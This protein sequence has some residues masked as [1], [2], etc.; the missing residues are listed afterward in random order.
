MS[1]ASS[2][3]DPDAAEARYLTEGGWFR[4]G[5]DPH[6]DFLPTFARSSRPALIN[7]GRRDYLSCSSAQEY[8]RALPYAQ[9]RFLDGSGHN[10][11]QDEPLQILWL[12]RDHLC[13]T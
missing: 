7:K 11:Y 12:D 6:A 4:P 1:W 9:L 13:Q 8:L 3:P 2:R 5:G 10:A